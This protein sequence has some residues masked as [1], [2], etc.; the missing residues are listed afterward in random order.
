MGEETEEVKKQRQASAL[1][2]FKIVLKN[3]ILE[4]F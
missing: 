3:Y 2:L 1:M 4:H